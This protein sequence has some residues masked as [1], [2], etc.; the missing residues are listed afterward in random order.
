MNTL[1]YSDPDEALGHLLQCAQ[2]VSAADLLPN[3]QAAINGFPHDARLRTMQA[4][5][6]RACGQPEAALDASWKA[7]VLSPK[8]EVARQELLFCVS[9]QVGLAPSDGHDFSLES[10]ERQTAPHIHGIRADHR[11]RYAWAARLLRSHFR[12]SSSLTG[13]D[14]FCG[15]GYGSRMISQL[16]GSRVI[17]IDGSTEAVELAERHYGNHRVAFG[18]AVFPFE[19]TPGL[20]DYAVSFESVEHVPD[21]EALLA[22]ICR[23][24]KGPVFLSVPNERSLPHA[25]FSTQFGFHFRHF[26]A[27][28]ICQFM[29]RLGF[30]CVLASA[31]QQVYRVQDKRLAGLLPESQMHLRPLTDNSQFIMLMFSREGVQAGGQTANPALQGVLG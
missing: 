31:G 16:T 10:G 30:P 8:D 29:R 1:A 7:L 28:D 23:S 20:F 14:A 13:L 6:H 15:N 25:D 21:S 17:G 24:T 18:Q 11:A 2:E 19:L 22:Q 9:E 26:T 5:L 12:D 4:I 3:A 27:E